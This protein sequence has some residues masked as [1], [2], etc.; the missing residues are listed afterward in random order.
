[1]STIASAL[2]EGVAALSPSDPGAARFE[3]ELLLCE[4]AGM[5][6]SGLFAWPERR[7][8]PPQAARFREMLRRRAEGEPVAYILGRREFWSLDIAVG[9][10]T[11]IPRPETELL[12][13]CALQALPADRALRCADLGTGSGAV[14]AA[15]ASERARWTLVAVDRSPRALGIAAANARRL[16][17]DN[18]LV[19][20]GHWLD[21]FAE[22]AFD[23]IV[24]NP[25]YVA[26]GDPHLAH[27]DLRFE[28]I[29]ALVAGDDGLAA[30]REIAAAAPSR[31]RPGGWLALEHGRDQGGAVRA[32]LR[33]AGLDAAAS[34]R[35]L[36]GHE[37]VTSAR[38]G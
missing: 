28:P 13:E 24:A 37:R 33:D 25:P 15:L 27:G 17:L 2:R 12:V 22:V 35:D 11:L 20:R 3:T 18:V 31:L 10:D 30:I 1:M 5:T 7:L 16:G 36:S 4:A 38:R 6:R 23:A 34:H 14:A 29:S 26:A 19:V 8:E 21:A 9:P 32:L